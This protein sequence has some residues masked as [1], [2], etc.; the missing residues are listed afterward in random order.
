MGELRVGISAPA[1][2]EVQGCCFA[3]IKARK[4][5]GKRTWG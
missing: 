1:V 4:R 5:D 2:A 3:V